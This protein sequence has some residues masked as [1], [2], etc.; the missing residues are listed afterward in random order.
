MKANSFKL[1]MVIAAAATI[2]ACSNDHDLFDSTVVEKDAK[3][4]YA[5]NFLK[6]YPNVD[7]NQSWDY[8][9]KT[10]RFSFGGETR[11][12]AVTRGSNVSYEFVEGRVQEVDLNT[13]AWM[14]ENLIEGRNNRTLGKAF[15]MTVPGTEF[16]IQPIFQG[17]AAAS[18][19]LHVV[20]DGIDIL[21]WHK[22]QDIELTTDA[23]PEWH[24]VASEQ[25]PNG[26]W[27]AQR[28]TLNAT[29]VRSVPYTF[30][31]L[32]VGAEMYFY[33]DITMSGTD[34]Q[35]W[36]G[37][38]PPPHYMNNV[39]DHMNSIDQMMLALQGFDKPSNVPAGNEYMIIGC[40][41]SN[42]E[43]SDWDMND[44]VFLVYGERI[45]KPI[46]I[47]EGTTVYDYKTVRYMIEDLGATDDFDFNDI[48]IDVVEST[49]KTPVYTNGV[50]TSWKTGDTTQKAIIRHLGGTLP[51]KLTIGDTELDEHE[52][53]LGSNP[54]ETYEISGWDMNLHNISVEV[55]QKGNEQVYNHVVFPKKGEAPMI[56]AVDPSEPWMSERQSVPTDWFYVPQQ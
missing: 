18:W 3:A 1:M 11:S 39:G 47:I 34:T 9:T 7:L 15:Y 13:V 30:K 10:S 51:F 50:L 4:A 41:D 6:K 26:G 16:T 35:N 48:V 44:V 45:P 40:E 14:K 24:T 23:N 49:A 27:E 28:H 37:N 12:D 38:V 53:V 55:R 21:L 32:P 43:H 33:L 25:N 5:E 2:V 8:S 42:L 17:E 31:N 29:A 54:N 22:S 52:G 36:W 46:E 56:I 19:D 20:V